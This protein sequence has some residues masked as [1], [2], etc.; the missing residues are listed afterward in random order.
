[1][2]DPKELGMGELDAASGGSGADC[3]YA[4][5]RVDRELCICCGACASEC[6]SGLPH[7]R[8][9]AYEIDPEPCIACGA[10]VDACPTGA[11][12]IA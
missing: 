5:A 3:S 8:G 10:C 7:Q 6:P 4:Y 1:M 2:S 12:R 11:I 9:E